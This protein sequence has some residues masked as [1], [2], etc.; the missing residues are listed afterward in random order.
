MLDYPQMF[1]VHQ[2]RE[3]PQVNDI[4]SEVDRQ[5]AGLKL[6]DRIQT[7]QTV[8]ISAGSRGIANIHIIIKAAV[9]H[10]QG[11]LSV[12]SLPVL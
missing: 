12:V 7:G 2:Q 5:L 8:A 3:R 6:A 10:L 9:A 1:R 11:N 4:P